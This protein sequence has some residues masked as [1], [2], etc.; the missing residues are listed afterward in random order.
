MDATE[1]LLNEGTKV[2]SGGFTVDLE[3]AAR[4]L[5]KVA[6]LEPGLMLGRLVQ[7]ATVAGA[8][9]IRFSVGEDTVE[10]KIFFEGQC[11]NPALTQ[12]YL[13]QAMALALSQKPRELSWECG[14]RHL[15][16]LK[17]DL[18]LSAQ[19]EVEHEAIPARGLSV[20]RY[21]ERDKGF[22]E[23]IFGG[24]RARG[25]YH[26]FLSKRCQVSPLP[27]YLDACR[28]NLIN[29]PKSEFDLTSIELQSA[30][31]PLCQRIAVPN[32]SL[33]CAGTVHLGGEIY[34]G[35]RPFF[36]VGLFDMRNEN[37]TLVLRG[38]ARA[39][40]V[41]TRGPNL[42]A[43]MRLTN[44]SELRNNGN[45]AIRVA[46]E[47]WSWED[48]ETFLSPLT[49]QVA[50][51]LHL[52]AKIW[53][54]QGKGRYPAELFPVVDGLMLNPVV[55]RDLTPG[56]RIIAVCSGMETDLEGMNVLQN[57]QFTKFVKSLR[58]F[59]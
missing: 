1:R 26:S 25:S 4:K 21:R 13:R 32:S 12:Q 35:D 43:A 7:A 28:L 2:G 39:R 47:E 10:A 56:T 9:Q 45:V 30:S 17:G 42:A 50:T 55:I 53:T 38:V 58:L 19:E 20:F 23:S 40:V 3:A 59:T 48:C 18:V 15:D 57:D 11:A 33:F 22:W 8:T 44:R 14:A 36:G 6:A 34:R 24:L 5:A 37:K 51:P 46:V 27:V 16:V 41:H 31:A 52:C 29:E 49:T 54:S